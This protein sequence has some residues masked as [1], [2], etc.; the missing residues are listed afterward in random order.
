MSGWPQ[1]ASTATNSEHIRLVEKGA[2]WERRGERENA[3]GFRCAIRTVRALPFVRLKPDFTS[4]QS[5][6]SAP[7]VLEGPANRCK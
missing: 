7:C 3:L 5:A 6:G 4:I 2:A 1:S